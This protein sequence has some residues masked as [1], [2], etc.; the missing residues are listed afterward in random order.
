MRCRPFARRR[1]GQPFPDSSPPFSVLAGRFPGS[2][3]RKAG[4]RPGQS[5][6][7]R[8][9][10]FQVICDA[11]LQPTPSDTHGHLHLH[12]AND[13]LRIPQPRRPNS[14]HYGGHGRQP[15][16]AVTT[17]SP[18]PRQ[19]PLHREAEKCFHQVFA[20][21]E[22]AMRKIG[23][24]GHHARTRA[25]AAPAEQATVLAGRGLYPKSPSPHPG[26]P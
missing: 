2:E 10:N 22:S 23:T 12:T 6:T 5:A 21:E 15:P 24:P 9:R 13:V 14:P 3:N 8:T 11:A 7:M 19:I 4:H 18:T 20:A 17:R 16:H 1:Q 25:F 26:P